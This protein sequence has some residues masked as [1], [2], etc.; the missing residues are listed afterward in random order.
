MFSLP[1]EVTEAV[2]EIT[3]TILPV[4]FDRGYTGVKKEIR[5]KDEILR[6]FQTEESFSF[7]IK[8]ACCDA[9]WKCWKR[10]KGIEDSSPP[11][12]HLYWDPIL[13]PPF[14]TR[15]FLP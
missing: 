15:S 1:D 5:K 11:D 13:S 9:L 10:L 8:Y 3:E 12:R 4:Y 2:T 14:T 6:I 7:D